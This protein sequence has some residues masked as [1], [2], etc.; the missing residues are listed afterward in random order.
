MCFLEVQYCCV[1]QSPVL[2]DQSQA[3]LSFMVYFQINIKEPVV[4]LGFSTC[5]IQSWAGKD[6]ISPN[7]TRKP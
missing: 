5:V 1:Q 3:G 7:P 2:P 4:I 6:P